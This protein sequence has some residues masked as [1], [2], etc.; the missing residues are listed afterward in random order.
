[1]L[2]FQDTTAGDG[3]SLVVNPTNDLTIGSNYFVQDDGS[4]ATTS[5]STK[6]GKAISTTALNLVDPT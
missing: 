4:L 5:S 1:V 6:A 2:A 3:E